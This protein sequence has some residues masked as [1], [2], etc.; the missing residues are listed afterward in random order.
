MVD[1]PP[2]LWPF[3]MFCDGADP[4]NLGVYSGY[5]QCSKTKPNVVGSYAADVIAAAVRSRELMAQHQDVSIS[6]PFQGM[7]PPME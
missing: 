4:V 2:Y 1:L 6:K 3:D 7:N 5:T